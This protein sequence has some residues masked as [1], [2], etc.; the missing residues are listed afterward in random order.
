[1]RGSRLFQH[2]FMHPHFLP[3]IAQSVKQL[4]LVQKGRERGGMQFSYIIVHPKRKKGLRK[5][6][7]AHRQ[8]R[9]IRTRSCLAP[10]LCTHLAI[11]RI[12]RTDLYPQGPVSMLDTPFFVS[13]NK[14]SKAKGVDRGR[15]GKEVEFL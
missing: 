8:V 9:S 14:R 1:L 12:M 13:P 10:L 6:Y 15:W 4:G 11:E 2:P 3:L 7:S 5:G